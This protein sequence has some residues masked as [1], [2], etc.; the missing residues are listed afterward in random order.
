MTAALKKLAA[1]DN[2]RIGAMVLG[3]YA[4]LAVLDKVLSGGGPFDKIISTLYTVCTGIL[5]LVLFFSVLYLLASQFREPWRE[6]ARVAVFVGP[7]LVLL[8]GGLIIPSL[9]TAKLSLYRGTSADQWYGLGNFRDM[10]T[11]RDNLLVLRN[12]VWWVILVTTFSTVIG[13]TI[14]RF[15]DRMRG[16]PVAKMLVFLPTAISFVGAGIIW[17][18]IYANNPSK[19]Y[20]L[21]NWVW[22][23][24]D[25]ILPGKQ[26]PHYWLQDQTFFGIK[27]DFLPGSNT[28][29][30]IIVMIWIQAGFATV[31]ISAAMK[32]VP[33]DLVEAAKIDGATDR[34]AFYK[35]VLPY[36]K[37]TIVT[38]VT[39][40]VIAVLKVFDLVQAMGLGGSFQNNVLANQMYTES[41][42]KQNEGYGSAA[43]V[44]IFIAVIPVVF[45]NARNQRVMRESR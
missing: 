30:M 8:V 9:L 35:I 4:V 21:L 24:L 6:R 22:V 3:V 37:T 43:A 40:T 11:K 20:G 7:A 41:F 14:A 32:G 13:V 27:S 36:V 23:G 5:V 38:V 18:F 17:R 25:P 45:V 12:N 42:T 44:V 2:V 19:Q 33:D 10:F 1:N 39:T 15:A 16:E 34:Q 29:F 26:E 31:V 28:V